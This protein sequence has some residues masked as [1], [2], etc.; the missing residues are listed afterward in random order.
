M[1]DQREAA[2]CRCRDHRPGE[3]NAKLMQSWGRMG[4]R[5]DGT[6]AGE[7]PEWEVMVQIT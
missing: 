2:M 4:R 5:T 3:S 6:G 7:E 1:N